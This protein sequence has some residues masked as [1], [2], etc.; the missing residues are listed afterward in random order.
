[1][2]MQKEL[3]GLLLVDVQEKLIP[4]VQDAEQLVGRCGWLMRLAYML[5]VPVLICEQ[6]PK[7][8]GITVEPLRQLAS[9]Y[10]PFEKV[11]FSCYRDEAIVKK[12]HQ[13]NKKQFIIMGIETHVCVLQTA[14]DIL[15]HSDNEVFIVVDAVSARSDHDHKYGLK[16]MKQAGAQ[17]VTHEM[18]FFEWVEKAGS[19]EFKSL[20][21]MFLR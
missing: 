15:Q 11:D 10:E 4:H 19:S 21:Q 6:Y 1:M 3:S 16:R 13:L 2:L 9:P 20:S 14:M 7:G 5:K 17:L 18:V 12:W 8:L